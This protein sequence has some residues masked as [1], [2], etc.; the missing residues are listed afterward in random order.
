MDWSTRRKIIYTSTAIILIVVYSLY[1]FRDVISPAP[2]CSDGKANGNENGVDC[3]GSCQ[4]VC[5]GDT[6]PLVVE[7]SSFIKTQENTYDLVAL[8]SNKNVNIDPLSTSYDFV[9]T[10]KDGENIFEKKGE[11][12]APVNSAFPIILQNIHL[13]DRPVQMSVSLS[14][15]KYFKT[16]L[17]GN[18]TLVKV[19]SKTFEEGKG[20]SR[21]YANIT[22]NTLNTLLKVRVGVILFDENKN[23]VG[24]GETFI[25]KLDGQE[26]RQVIW[27]WNTP[28]ENKPLT[29]DVYP[30]INPFTLNK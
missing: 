16:V 12:V 25:D 2:T 5:V 13:K 4:L 30:I 19:T 7:W 18:M 26:K 8:V 6:K 17:N 23:A 10:N 28:F 21:V 14:S 1:H 27:T 22:N 9:L 24:V 15:G 3:G 29:V 20:I 11:I